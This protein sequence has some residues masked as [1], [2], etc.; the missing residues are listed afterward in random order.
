MTLPVYPSAPHCNINGLTDLGAYAMRGMMDRGM[1]I[2]IDHM[3]QKAA[4]QAL[5]L[6]EARNYPGA[7]SSHSWTDPSYYPRIYSLGGVA[8]PVR[9]RHRA[10]PRRVAL[11]EGRR[12]PALPVRLRRRASTPTASAT[13]RRR[14]RAAPCSTRSS[15]FDGGSTVD[16]QRTG[17]RVYD[18]NVDGF[19]HYGMLPDWLQDLR[20]VAGPD[21]RRDRRRHESW[22]G[23]LPADPGAGH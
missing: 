12:R 4:D 13:S 20:L 3:S 5:D 2:D 21:G 9:L 17:Q 16:R 18:V 23:G 19:A 22:R 14:D 1:L 7:V 6:M 15:T 8:V 10:V 11:D